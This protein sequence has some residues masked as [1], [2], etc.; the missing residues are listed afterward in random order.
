MILHSRAG[1]GKGGRDDGMPTNARKTF[2][3]WSQDAAQNLARLEASEAGLSTA[4]AERRLKAHGPN[5]VADSKH[6]SAPR[7]LLRQFE[8]PLVLILVFGAVISLGLKEWVDA[9]VILAIVAGSA[10][11]GFVQEYRASNA[12]AQLRARLALRALALRD[13]AL[14]SVPASDLAPGDI[15]ALSAGDLIPADCLLL[16]AKDFL[17]TEA[18]LT[19]ES[20]PVEKRPGIVPADATIGGRTNA[21]FLGASVRSGAARALVIGT[22]RDTAFGEIAA[23]LE[24][25][26]AETD[27]ARGVR[28]FGGMLLRVMLV[29]VALV[30]TINQYLGRPIDQSLLFAVALA[31]GLSPELLP[32]IVSVTLARGAT[33]LAARGVLVRR[34]EA[35]ENLGGMQ[36][37]CTDKTGTLTIGTVRM[38]GAVDA[39]GRPSDTV[40]QLGYTNAVLETGIANP[41]DAAIREAGELAGLSAASLQKIDEIPYDFSRRRLTILFAGEDGAR[42]MVT[43]GAFANVA[44]ICTTIAGD[45]G[46]RPLDDAAMVQLEN[47]VRTQ[48]NAGMR[49]LA[50]AQRAAPDKSSFSVEDETGMTFVGF[51]LFLD[52]PKADAARTLKALN[53]R[54]VQV[55]VITGDNRYVAAHVADAVGL[56][57]EASLTGADL[58]QTSDEALWRL[59]PTTDVFAEI[60]PQQKERIVRALQR[61]GLSVGYLGDGINDAPALQAAD[62]GI[63][64]ETAVDVARASADVVLLK[65]DLGVVCVGVEEGRHTFANTLKYIHITTSANFGNMVSMAIA[66]PFLPFLPL[67]PKQILLNNFASDLPSATI[68]TDDVDPEQI[69]QPQQWNVPR[70]VRFMVVFGLVSSVFDL[71]TF[72]FLLRV[73]DAQ[74]PLFQTAWFCVSLLTELVVVLILRTQRPAFSSRPGRLLLWATIAVSAVTIVL[75]FLG[76]FT[77]LFGFAP[78]SL[79]DLGVVLAIVIAY[80]AATEAVKLWFVRSR[81]N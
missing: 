62:V 11:L 26:E 34:L 49:V 3:F 12:I 46:D 8:S 32:A 19:G 36:V 68:A 7:L 37:F 77:R 75:P 74:E 45:D 78:L 54:N 80:A 39:L 58:A 44:A 59:A 63:S 10:L 21:V 56:N 1:R 81:F 61:T 42:R 76:G 2:P 24:T 69:A 41:L 15:I 20:F 14:Q 16:E 47:F 72:A 73:I 67:L 4:E 17:V 53:D 35:I 40:R 25:A 31:V 52:P 71:L 27:F 50:V 18:S 65:P 51:L 79:G 43:K 13:G 48:G 29:I 30:L 9:S 60:D 5:R 33:M 28:R 70:L 38:S 6:L 57:A 23:S 64:V 55:K 22:G 66:T